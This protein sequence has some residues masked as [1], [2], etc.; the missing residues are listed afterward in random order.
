M[1][2]FGETVLDLTHCLN[3]KNQVPPTYFLDW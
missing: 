2:F 3:F 1:M